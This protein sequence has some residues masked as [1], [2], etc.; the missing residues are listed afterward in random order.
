MFRKIFCD[1]DIRPRTAGSRGLQGLLEKF[2]RALRVIEFT[3]VPVSEDISD[4]GI[5]FSF[6]TAVQA[7][8]SW[9]GRQAISFKLPTR[10]GRRKEEGRSKREGWRKEIRRD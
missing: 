7:S 8:R 10:E 9:S 2:S 6:W 3:A 4:R 1:I 5:V